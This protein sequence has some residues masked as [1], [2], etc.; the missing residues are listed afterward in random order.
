MVLYRRMKLKRRIDD[1][2]EEIY[3]RELLSAFHNDNMEVKRSQIQLYETLGE[4]AF[5]IV[6]KGK[7]MPQSM[8]V[9]VK[10]VKGGIIGIAM[11]YNAFDGMTLCGFWLSDTASEEGVRA[12][13]KELLSEIQLMKS[14]GPHENIVGIVGHYTTDDDPAQ[15]MLLTEYCSE[16]NLLNYLR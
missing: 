13:V 8:E 1:Q 6:R 3:L 7:L 15:M 5:G 12:S 2:S 11:V 14:V 10:M 4:G 16:G 9:A